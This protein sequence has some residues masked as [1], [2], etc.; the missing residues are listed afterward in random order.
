[1]LKYF[2]ALHP[3]HLSQTH[4]HTICAHVTYARYILNNVL[5]CKM[6]EMR[7]QWKYNRW[8]LTT[9]RRS[10]DILRR[11]ERNPPNFPKRRKIKVRN[12]HFHM[13]CGKDVLHGRM[14]RRKSRQTKQTFILNIF[15]W[16]KKLE[17]E[18]PAILGIHMYISIDVVDGTDVPWRSN[19]MKQFVILLPPLEAKKEW[20]PAGED[21]LKEWVVNF[22]IYLSSSRF[23]PTAY[24][25]VFV[26]AF[27]W[28]I[29]PVVW[30]G[31]SY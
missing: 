30:Y 10:N 8:C 26:N 22:Q 21:L 29:P 20:V 15:T 12:C 19:V 13:Q 6:P 18:L 27:V 23:Q 24:F 9:C 7:R 16:T 1:M 5:Q 14:K 3:R 2:T 4:T 25:S 17:M 31:I 11:F 28:H